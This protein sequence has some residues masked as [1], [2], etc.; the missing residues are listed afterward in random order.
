[1]NKTS[2]ISSTTYTVP[3][4]IAGILEIDNLY[5]LSIKCK[6]LQTNFD[7]Y[8]SLTLKSVKHSCWNHRLLASLVYEKTR[9]V[10]M[11]GITG[12]RW[13]KQL[14]LLALLDE[15]ALQVI[16]LLTIDVTANLS[17]TI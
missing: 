17:R 15:D 2:I 7:S 8:F 4:K 9:Y 1:M 3:L 6:N 12:R 13:H 14:F 5:Q 11:H 10:A 16:S